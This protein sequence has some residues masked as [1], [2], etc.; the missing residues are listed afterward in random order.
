MAT[1]KKP[2]KHKQGIPPLMKMKLE[3]D[4][5]KENEKAKV[6][7]IEYG[8]L[9]YKIASLAYI[10]NKTLS[11]KEDLSDFAEMMNKCK[12][13]ILEKHPIIDMI[14]YLSKEGYPI[15]TDELV[16]IDSSLGQYM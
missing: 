14:D 4:F 7:G 2:P 8:M 13:F 10:K 12:E 16:E 5:R 15:T 3:A 1:N 6:A 9:T 11:S